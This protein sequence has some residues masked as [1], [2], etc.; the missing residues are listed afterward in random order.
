MFDRF[1][2]PKRILMGPGPTNVPETVLSAL[3]APTVGHLDPSFMTLMDEIK[4]MLQTVF[5]T[6][7]QLT[8]PISAPGS[9]GMES[10]FVNLVESGD[11]V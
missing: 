8:M 11:E 6:K 9:A 2:P 3:G 7:N 5:N 10:C 1:I 4:V